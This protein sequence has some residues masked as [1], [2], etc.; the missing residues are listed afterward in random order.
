MSVTSASTTGAPA[1]PTGAPAVQGVPDNQ[2]FRPLWTVKSR[3]QKSTLTATA[4]SP[5]GIWAASASL[6]CNILFLDFRTG[7]S[8]GVLSFENWFYAMS[9][10]WDTD[11][12][13]FA[14]CSDGGLLTIQFSPANKTPL[15]IHPIPL[16]P[17]GTAITAL[18]LDPLRDMLAVGYGG[19]VSVISRPPSGREGLWKLLDTIPEP[20]EGPHATV[21]ALGFVGESLANRRLIAGYAK[22][23]FCTWTAPGEYHSTPYDA[24]GLVCSIGSA[25]FSSDG[26]FV[27][28]A[29]LD[30]SLVVYPMSQKGGPVVHQRQFL[31]NLERATHRPI[32]PIA[33][34]ANNLVLRGSTTGKVPVV[35]LQSGPLAPIEHGAQEIIRCLTAYNDKVV[36]GLSD[37]TGQV[38][39]IKCYLD[40]KSPLPNYVRLQKNNEDPLFQIGIA[41][42]ERQNNLL[43]RFARSKFVGLVRRHY[44]NCSKRVARLSEHMYNRDTWIVLGLVWVFLVVLVV[45]PPNIPGLELFD[46][47]GDRQSES[48]TQ[49]VSTPYDSDDNVR[50]PNLFSL[51]TF[52]IAY[53]GW[54]FV[55]WGCFVVSLAGLVIGLGVT[56]VIQCVRQIPTG[57]KIFMTDLP[58][59]MSAAICKAVP[60]IPICPKV[61]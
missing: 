29:T 36:V 33:L 3:F 40:R 55:L 9:L 22:A 5:S 60:D 61:K 4:V 15:A 58:A 43:A 27:A 59:F 32:I 54:R 24:K 45:D 17:F 14:G 37:T 50:Y 56:M 19:K 16:K 10:R 8:I 41:E 44:V 42:L 52:C 21:T 48:Y 51:V 28:I 26:R 39:Q 47:V 18:A 53:V 12:L 35:D 1:V 34:A 23:G 2:R 7:Q 49:D 20:A 11:G 6:D 38:S 30:H 57:I 13:L 25:A 31:P 46:V